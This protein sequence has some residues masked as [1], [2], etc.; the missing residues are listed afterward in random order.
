MQT[1]ISID[2]FRAFTNDSALAATLFSKH[3][4]NKLIVGFNFWAFIF[5]FSWFFFKRMHLTGL[6]AFLFFIYSFYAGIVLLNFLMFNV[7]AFE[8]KWIVQYGFLLCL[9]PP[10]AMTGFFANNVLYWK[11]LKVIGTARVLY[12]EQDERMSFIR[13][14]GGESY[15]SAWLSVVAVYALNEIGRLF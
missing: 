6:I 11:A 14:R 4:N 1:N 10:M 5:H 8:Q 2:E 13:S 7:F 12:V 15:L 9:L 3:K